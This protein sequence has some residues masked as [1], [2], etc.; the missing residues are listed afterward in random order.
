MTTNLKG[1]YNLITPTGEA[2]P[3]YMIDGVD[4][5]NSAQNTIVLN[6]LADLDLHVPESGGS[7]TFAADTNYIL[8][9]SITTA[10]PFIIGDNMNLTA[11]NQQFPTLTYSGTGDMFTA[12]DKDFTMNDLRVS[13]PLAQC[14]NVSATAPGANFKAREVVLDV[15]LKYGTFDDQTTLLLNNC[16]GL[17]VADGI[18]LTGTNWSACI[19]ERAGMFGSDAGFIGI[20]LTTAVIDDLGINTIIFNGPAG[21]TGI[22]GLTSSG[23][24]PAN[25]VSNITGCD[26]TAV[27]TPL[28]GLDNSDIRLF[29]LGNDG[30]LDST[31]S[32]DVFLTASRTTP[33]AMADTYVTIGGTSFSSDVS[34]RFSTTT[35]GVLT[36][37]PEFD[38]Q[39]LVIMTA[40]IEKVGGGTDQICGK[41]AINGTE[42]D[43]TISCSENASP[44]TITCIG[45]FVLSESDTIEGMVANVDATADII[46]SAANISVIN[47][48]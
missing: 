9:G 31:I 7:R 4:V 48:F 40:T 37:L 47:G 26:F 41:I 28:T 19:I 17:Q 39:T 11:N 25:K 27:T 8:G 12:I 15:C 22:S 43:K 44:T 42:S 24:I 16:S 34:E 20:D 32:G 46:V 14:F 36:Y 23:N 13:C 21:S 29:F 3:R 1:N 2:T 35:G 30:V 45:L 18:T 33:I 38:S 10:D 6:T 5:I